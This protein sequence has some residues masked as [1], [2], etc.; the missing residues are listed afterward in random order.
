M[1]A[2]GGP[3]RVGVGALVEGADLVG[4][5]TRGV[6]DRTGRDR[7]PLRAP[8]PGPGVEHLDVDTVDDALSVLAQ[9]D[10]A[11]V[12]G[13]RGAELEHGGAQD[14]D[15]QTGIV[16]RGVVVQ[17]RGHQPVRRKRGHES[18]GLVEVEAFVALADPPPAGQVVAPHGR[19]Q[20]A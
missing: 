19:A 16:R 7:E 1:Y 11:H 17:V 8:G 10:G 14:R 12:V 5:H 4:P 15:D 20:Q 6:D 2:L 3:D 13:A 18:Q 9:A